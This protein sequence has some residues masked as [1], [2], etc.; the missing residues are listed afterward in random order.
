MVSKTLCAYKL[1]PNSIKIDILNRDV[2][3]E[4]YLVKTCL[5]INDKNQRINV[6]IILKISFIFSILKAI[7][8]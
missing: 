2:K 7:I 6:F 8:I 5:K 1:K 3:I 4:H